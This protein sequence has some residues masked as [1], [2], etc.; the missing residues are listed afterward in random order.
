M[1]EKKMMLVA[2][3][4]QF[5]GHIL[6]RHKELMEEQKQQLESRN[7]SSLQSQQQEKIDELTKEVNRLRG[8]L[9][10][11]KFAH[12]VELALEKAKVKSLEDE[13][14][15]RRERDGSAREGLV[16]ADDAE[17]NLKIS[18]EEKLHQEKDLRVQQLKSLE[19]LHFAEF[20]EIEK[21]HADFVGN[22][23][24]SYQKEINVLKD[25]LYGF[26]TER[27]SEINAIIASASEKPAT[28][29]PTIA[30]ALGGEAAAAAAA[31]SSLNAP[32]VVNELCI[33]TASTVM[34]SGAESTNSSDGELGGNKGGSKRDSSQVSDSGSGGEEGELK[35]AAKKLC[36]AKS[37]T[38]APA[39]AKK[40]GYTEK[41]ATKKQG[42]PPLNEKR[43]IYIPESVKEYLRNW[44]MS[45]EH[46]EHPYPTP[47]EKADIMANTGITL[48]ELNNWFVNN[49]A[50]FWVNTVRPQ[51]PEIKKA[52][53]MRKLEEFYK[54]HEA[55]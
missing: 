45:P 35:P 31:L 24:A 8:K 1:K 29:E 39:L 38:A 7:F 55:I 2:F 20:R 50:R 54:V 3:E 41:A 5:N 34:D 6:A 13:L 23:V 25:E 43:C 53:R 16:P 37:T 27:T 19:M 15:W 12:G 33:P 30:S 44:M 51:I 52:H 17:K 10:E 46:C 36:T 40:K 48:K 14:G 28:E 21:K 22:L 49:R 18:L 32:S 9:E 4:E 11:Q 42:P 47:E 26:K